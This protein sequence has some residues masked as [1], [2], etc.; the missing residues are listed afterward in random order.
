VPASPYYEITNYLKN[1]LNKLGVRLFVFPFTIG[2]YERSIAT[3]E[4]NFKGDSPT[5][6]LVQWNPWL[7]QQFKFNPASYLNMIQVCRRVH[8]IVGDG[9]LIEENYGEVE[10][11]LN[12]HGLALERTWEEYE[13]DEVRDLWINLR[14]SMA[15]NKWDLSR[16]WEFI[17][18]QGRASD[19]VIKHDVTSIKNIVQLGRAEGTDEL[20]PRVFFLTLD[21][22][23][24]RLRKEYDSIISVEQFTEF[25][26]PYL[27]LADIPIQEAEQFPNQLLSAQLGT[28]LVERSPSVTETILM[29]LGQPSLLDN[30]RLESRKIGE[31]ASELSKSRYKKIFERAAESSEVDRVEAAGRLSE[32]VEESMRAKREGVYRDI[33]VE[34]LKQQVERERSRADKLQ[35]RLRYT[36]R[37]HNPN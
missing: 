22:K 37:H 2:E 10:A 30:H 5:A 29:F 24:L 8:S 25:I 32:L 27:F 14:N 23:L 21:S 18:D 11:T 16:Y 20:G 15:S 36:R 28:L 6:F 17:Y 9:E 26:L 13:E 34:A 35:R 7:F 3:V 12:D 31:M 19:E 1:R 4:S 33:E